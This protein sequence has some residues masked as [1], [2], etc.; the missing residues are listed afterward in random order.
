MSSKSYYQS[1]SPEQK[2]EYNRRANHA[3]GRK[4]KRRENSR[5]FYRG[6]SPEQRIELHH[7]INQNP[8]KRKWRLEHNIRKY[9][10]D[11][12]QL[13]EMF[14]LQEAK[15]A[16]CQCE[17]TTRR[18]MHIDHDHKTGQ[19]RQ[20]LCNHCNV[21]LG[22]FKETELLLERALSY[23]RKWKSPD[24]VQISTDL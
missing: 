20:L 15:C 13:E 3:P 17:F 8:N 12:K 7:Q 14:L 6:L 10:L 22:M 4:E 21:G 19:I 5:R 24:P 11:I 2:R 23:L 18:K 9:G 16:I 1:L